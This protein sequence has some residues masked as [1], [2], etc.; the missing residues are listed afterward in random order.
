MAR[1]IATGFL[2]PD[3]FFFRLS[4]WNVSA[5]RQ[6]GG[7][8]KKRRHI[9]EIA[10]PLGGLGSPYYIYL[11]IIGIYTYIYYRGKRMNEGSRHDRDCRALPRPPHHARAAALSRA[12]LARHDRDCR[13]DRCRL[14]TLLGTAETAESLDASPRHRSALPRLPRRRGL[15]PRIHSNV[16][17]YAHI[18]I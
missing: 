10:R 14:S 5:Y 15:A 8:G 3:A 11:G 13:S 17:S 4:R 12:D 16:W 6:L 7:E 2:T 18:N 9:I 1:R